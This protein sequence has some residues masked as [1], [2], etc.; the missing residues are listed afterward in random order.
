MTD[1]IYSE[2]LQLD[3]DTYDEVEAQVMMFFL[4]LKAQVRR[5]KQQRQQQKQLI[6]QQQQQLHQQQQAQMFQPMFSQFQHPTP[7]KQWTTLQ[8]ISAQPS[9]TASL[10]PA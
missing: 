4:Q 10:Q 9:S 3:M 2:C 8:T 1:Y 6:I 7:E 5:D